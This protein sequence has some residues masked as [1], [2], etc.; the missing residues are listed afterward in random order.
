MA[1]AN[2]AAMRA[3]LAVL[4]RAT[5]AARLLGYEGSASGL[6]PEKSAQLAD[7]MDAVHNIPYLLCNWERCDE[8]LL[9]SMLKDYDI[10]WTSLLAD[11]YT[12]IR[13]EAAT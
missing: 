2:D 11:E 1:F 6:S 9:L 12:R 13:A 10:K 4:E 3:G 7:L 5:V 8:S